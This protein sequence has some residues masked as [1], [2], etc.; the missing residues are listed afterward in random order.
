MAQTTAFDT[1]GITV[2][3]WFIASPPIGPNLG[4]M[5]EGTKPKGIGK[6]DFSEH[7]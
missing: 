5:T 7:S 4:N 1:G 6:S 2:A 3:G